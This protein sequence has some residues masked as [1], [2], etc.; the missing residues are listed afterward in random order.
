M[1]DE[2]HKDVS[3][4]ELEAV[5]AKSYEEVFDENTFTDEVELDVLLTKEE[6]EAQARWA[7]ANSNGTGCATS[8]P[9]VP[10]GRLCT[11]VSLRAS[12]RRFPGLKFSNHK[13]EG[14]CP[15]SHAQIPPIGTLCSSK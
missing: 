15:S 3:F 9:S 4:E 8:P 6:K 7:C 1:I 13:C 10:K 11:W 5:Y 14:A 12:P 2:A